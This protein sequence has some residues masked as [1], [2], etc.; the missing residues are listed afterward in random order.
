MLTGNPVPKPSPVNNVDWGGSI[1]GKINHTTPPPSDY[2]FM[3]SSAELNNVNWEP[4][5]KAQSS[6][7]C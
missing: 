4:S 6:E 7:Q 1:I 3:K 2:F 5:P